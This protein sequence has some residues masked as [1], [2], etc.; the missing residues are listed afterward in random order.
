MYLAFLERVVPTNITYFHFMR[1]KD[2]YSHYISILYGLE[3]GHLNSSLSEGRH[4]YGKISDDDQRKML[5]IFSHWLYDMVKYYGSAIYLKSETMPH[6]INVLYTFVVGIV[7]NEKKNFIADYSADQRQELYDHLLYL[8]TY[9]LCQSN[10][11][12]NYSMLQ[13]VC[14]CLSRLFNCMEMYSFDRVIYA[15]SYWYVEEIGYIN[16]PIL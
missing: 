14:G 2:L 12:N 6:L 15:A 11:E 7:E 5:K 8:S 1:E 13:I 9:I 4:I 3:F 16:E 10:H